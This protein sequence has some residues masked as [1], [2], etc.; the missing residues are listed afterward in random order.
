MAVNVLEM[1]RQLSETRIKMNEL[2]SEATSA[3]ARAQEAEKAMRIMREQLSDTEQAL[4]YQRQ[5]T[6]LL[7]SALSDEDD[8]RNLSFLRGVEL[9]GAMEREMQLI[10]ENK[11]LAAEAQEASRRVAEAESKLG[12]TRISAQKEV[13]RLAMEL[14]KV[15][16]LYKA[17]GNHVE[18]TKTEM[19][20]MERQEA[21]LTARCEVLSRPT[22]HFSYFVFQHRCIR[23][24]FTSLCLP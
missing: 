3:S 7:Q 17:K 5:H 13:D 21:E 2:A 19:A 4:L 16:I 12:F 11:R 22:Q 15:F 1:T 20:A 14:S 18:T 8:R 6:E 23:R 10:T 9:Q 24:C